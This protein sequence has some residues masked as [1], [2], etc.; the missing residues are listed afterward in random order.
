MRTWSIACCVF[1]MALGSGGCACS[2][3]TESALEQAPAAGVLGSVALQLVL[4]SGL[5]FQQVS[6]SIRFPDGRTQMQT[7]DLR[8][9]DSTISAQ[10]SELPVGNGYEV[11]L[12]GTSTTGVPCSGTS[13]FDIKENEEVVVIVDMQCGGGTAAPAVGAARVRGEVIPNAGECPAVID[14]VVVAPAR[15]GIGVPVS[16][17]VFPTSGPAPSVA[18]SSD[19]GAIVSNGARATFRCTEEGEF[20]VFI[21]ATRAGCLHQAEA[22]VKCFDDGTPYVV[23]GAGGTGGGGNMGGGNAGGGT[24]NACQTCTSSNCAAQLTSCQSEPSASACQENRTCSN[25]GNNM[26]C[27][28]SSSLACYCGTRSNA[29]CLA[30]GGNGACADVIARSSGCDGED[31]PGAVA[32]CVTE[33]FLDIAYG[34]GDA[35]QLVACQRRNCSTQCALTR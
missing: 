8:P 33:R 3:G 14:R 32:L 7:I 20:L 15:A 25:V 11:T 34:L 35:Y 12:A 13:L 22:A 1:G 30:M 6:L 9:E 24:A 19:G 16:V 26:S 23:S 5:I 28:A 4:D 29:T 2:N 18:F 27:A 31:D 17:D 21:D 10:L